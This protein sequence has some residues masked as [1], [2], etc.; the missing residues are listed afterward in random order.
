MD[1]RI[2]P[3]RADD[4]TAIAAFTQDTF[5]WGDYVADSFLFWL[6]DPQGLVMVAVNSQDEPIGLGRAVMLSE[7]EGWLHGARVD[8][9]HRR[10]GVGAAL[11]RHGCEWAQQKGA[12]VVRLLVEVWNEPARRQ[13]EKLGY[14]AVAPWLW[15]T[16]DTRSSGVD[17]KTNGGKRVQSD[18]R[19][20]PGSSAE[21][22]PAWIAWSTSALAATGRQLYPQG[23]TFRTMTTN[24]VTAAAKRRALWHCPSGWVIA[25]QSD[26]DEL[27][28][29][30][31]VTSDLDAS[32]LLRA[33]I[34]RAE[35]TTVSGLRVFAPQVG[36]LTEAL[37][38]AGFE[39]RPATIFALGL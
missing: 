4:L 23:W 15:A 13:V 36:W 37:E 1:V 2:R 3:A 26:E 14:R 18:E 21:V 11:N 27:T 31:V 34:D 6:E 32:R 29:S 7:R 10:Q 33:L 17:P 8:P 5:E 25:D 39:L 12:R 24:D 9:D 19:L 38:Q 28:V 30:W 16:R 35:A 22:E 20:N